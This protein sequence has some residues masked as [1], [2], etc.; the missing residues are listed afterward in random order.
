MQTRGSQWLGASDY[1]YSGTV[2]MIV[3][4]VLLGLSVIGAGIGLASGDP[5]SAFGAI[6][7]FLAGSINLGI[8]MMQKRRFAP[9][10]VSDVTL[11][12]EAKGLLMSLRREMYGWQ[13]PWMTPG[14]Y[15]GPMMMHQRRM[16]RRSRHY[17]MFNGITPDMIPD[18]LAPNE[19]EPLE[20]AAAEYNRVA[21]GVAMGNSGS[22]LLAK[23]GPRVVKAADE[24]MADVLHQ[25]A[26]LAKYPEGIN[27]AR[28]RLE[29]QIHALK[30][31]ADRVEAM[32]A[33]QPNLTDKVAYRSS[34]DDVLD[35]LR[36]EQ[37]A[38]NELKP[39]EKENRLT[40]SE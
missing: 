17:A 6:G 28:A 19:L 25:T 40:S 23:M 37:L 39:E 35:E 13:G 1:R 3:G 9:H 5:Q 11:T 26:M 12:P 21:G 36:L 7:P 14:F 18:D 24:V 8:G 16:A 29:A 30:E 20:R 38:R 2:Q 33:E 22:A 34:I 15:V 32:A 4:S 27:A 31:L 10:A